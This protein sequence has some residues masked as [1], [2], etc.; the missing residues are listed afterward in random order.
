MEP[1]WIAP[2]LEDR[3]ESARHDDRDQGWKEPF[4]RNIEDMS[5]VVRTKGEHMQGS[6]G[7]A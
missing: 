3:E 4:G 2:G 6:K 7:R 1:D 5:A